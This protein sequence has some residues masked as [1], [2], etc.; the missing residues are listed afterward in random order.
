MLQTWVTHF[1][2]FR[3]RAYRG[4]DLFCEVERG[5]LTAE[6][7]R[8]MCP[9]SVEVLTHSDPL[10]IKSQTTWNVTLDFP[11]SQQI[12]I[13]EW[14]RNR[15]RNYVDLHEFWSA[16]LA[17][18]ARLAGK[19]V[20]LLAF[21]R[22]GERPTGSRALDARKGRRIFNLRN[23]AHPTPFRFPPLQSLESPWSLGRFAVFVG[24]SGCAWDGLGCFS[25]SCLPRAGSRWAGGKTFRNLNIGIF[26]PIVVTHSS[27]PDTI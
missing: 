26:G 20:W 2:N 8:S 7:M 1:G 16:G 11:A 21:A 9:I 19:T 5:W 22:M 6:P 14:V 23:S 24:A 18:L 25:D 12:L 27:R 3:N 17:G 15:I 13:L 10:K 4:F